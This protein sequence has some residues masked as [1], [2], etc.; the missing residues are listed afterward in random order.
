MRVP[1]GFGGPPRWMTLALRFL[2]PPEKQRSLV[3]DL[4]EAYRELQGGEGRRVANAWYASQVLRSISPL[5]RVFL[6]LSGVDFLRRHGVSLGSLL[7]VV[8]L[9][10][11]RQALLDNNAT[12]RTLAES[13]GRQMH[14]SRERLG[15]AVRANRDLQARIDSLLHRRMRPEPNRQPI[16]PALTA[17]ARPETTEPRG[18]VTIVSADSIAGPN[19][20][21]V[22][23]GSTSSRSEVEPPDAPSQPTG[24]VAGTTDSPSGTH[25]SMRAGAAAAV[26]L[27]N[28]RLAWR[29]Q[30]SAASQVGS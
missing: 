4:E 5:A 19:I 13:R 2:L 3:G 8:V 17:V 23:N 27:A 29:P 24:Q 15:Q 30:P 7:V 9:T 26:D 21:T 28:G 10:M 25:E 16:V 18:M 12:L 14:E 22:V 1:G 11:G 6:L 20:A